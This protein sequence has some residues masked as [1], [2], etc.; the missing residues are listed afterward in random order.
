MPQRGHPH[1]ISCWP[2]CVGDPTSFIR[3]PQQW[4][5][6]LLG[7]WEI[8][9]LSVPYLT[10]FW[11]FQKRQCALCDAMT[12]GLQPVREINSSPTNKNMSVYQWLCLRVTTSRYPT[13]G[14]AGAVRARV[15][16]LLFSS[17]SLL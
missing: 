10:L 2:P 12:D 14:P 1:R 6:E 15:C 16:A 4:A 13:P 11:T 8:V 17:S 5:E 3:T 7:E 9:L